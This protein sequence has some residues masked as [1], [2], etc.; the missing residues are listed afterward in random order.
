MIIIAGKNNIAVH[1]LELALRH[2]PA[3]Q[4]AVV[5]N[6]NEPGADHW[7][8]SLR[9]A[10]AR[11]GV[12]EISLEAAYDLA[13]QAF[14]SLEFDQ[15]VVPSRFSIANIFNIHFSRLP[16]YKGMYT[17]VWPILHGRDEA[18]VTLHHIEPGIDT[19]DIVDQQV[20]PIADWWTCRDLYLAFTQQ[21][22]EVLDRCFLRLINTR[23]EGRPQ[24]ANGSSYFSKSSIDY[25]NLRINTLATA[26]ECVTQIRAFA[27][28]EYQFLKWQGRPVVSATV[29]ADKSLRKPGFVLAENDYYA[30]I[31]TIDY[32][33]RF[34]FDKLAD[35]LAACEC[36]DMQEVIRLQGNIAGYN[37]ANDKGWTPL[38]VA[39][40]AGAYDVVNWL[41]KKGASP[42]RPNNKGTTPLMYAKDAYFSG[43]CRRTFFLLLKNAAEL[44]TYDYAGKKLSD[45]LN[46]E[47]YAQLLAPRQG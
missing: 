36:A 12:K 43:R 23:V 31:A 20:F 27:F 46:G 1:G 19:G 41:L 42:V 13:T 25:S 11:W 34:H 38:I 8:R 14:I 24:P 18:G 45:Y 44:E 39:S 40:Y 28:R 16:E 5:C 6:R 29:L 37:D 26:W 30:D 33:V 3:E 7:Q 9:Q 15:L 10:A 32:N 47:Q 22:S 4:L 17:S 21:A 35:M 2:F